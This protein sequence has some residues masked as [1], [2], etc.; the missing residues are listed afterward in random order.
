MSE[1]TATVSAAASADAPLTNFTQCHAGIVRRLNVLDELPALLEPAARARSLAE[2]SLAFFREAIYEHHLDEERELFPAVLA[3]AQPGVERD[4]VQTMVDRLTAQHRTLEA[5]WKSMERELKRVAR[6][7]DSELDA[8]D[9]HRLVSEY[10][11]HVRYEE[12]DFLP[13]AEAILGRNDNHM[14]ALGLSLHLRH[15]PQPVPYV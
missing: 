9:V 5:L 14:A 3:S 1:T 13:A 2:Q 6:G 7:Q 11:A 4:R 10:V 12:T 8:N 15:A